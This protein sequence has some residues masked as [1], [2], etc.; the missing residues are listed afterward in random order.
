MD[1]SPS[2]P[3]AEI[4]AVGSEM[5]T[6][7]KVDTNSLWLTDSLNALGIE[8]VRKTVVGDD[9]GRLVETIRSA[10]QPGK[11]ILITGGLGPTEDDVTRE[12][13]AAAL[14]RTLVVNE[15]IV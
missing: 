8:V 6:P 1:G 10:F 13:A 3:D 11:I 14:G 7:S 5:L 15:E 12:A 4:I 9:R 2:R